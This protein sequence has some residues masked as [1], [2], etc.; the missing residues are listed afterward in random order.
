MS[1]RTGEDLAAPTAARRP[2]PSRNRK[3]VWALAA[4]TVF[5]VGD[6]META[7]LSP[8][9]D[10]LG[11]DAG[12]VALLWSAY[13]ASAAI[14]AWAAGALAQA[15]GSKRVIMTGAAIWLA[16][17]VVFLVFGV[18][19]GS[20][21]LMLIA[22]TVRAA[23]YAMFAF[24]F[25]VWVNDEAEPR[26]LHKSVGWY[27]FAYA[28][29]LGVISSYVAG[30]TLPVIGQLGTLWLAL[31]FVAAGSAIALFKVPGAAR[32][33]VP[34]AESLGSLV[35]GITVIRDHPRVGIGGVVRVINT[36]SFYAFVAFLTTY[37]VKQ[38]GFSDTEW[39]LIWGT[40]LFANVLANIIAGYGAHYLGPR[41]IIT[42]AGGFGCFV[43][44][45]ALY[46]VPTWIGPNFW[47]TIV[48]AVVYGLALG[49]FVPLSALIPQLAG[50]NKGPAIAVLNLGAGASQLVGPVLASLVPVIGM[51]PVVWV[52]A[53]LYLVGMVLTQFLKQPRTAAAIA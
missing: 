23:G 37:M 3:L 4:L 48:I 52:I 2:G 39:Q 10:T 30:F 14:A 19:V 47:V 28:L 49:M 40:M 16:M 46:F 42:W 8:Y 41:Q 38:I 12:R 21:P 25:L 44:V 11:F 32:R 22:F 43:T 31:A 20:Y 13:G 6:G 15:W 53:T 26:T 29:G 1:A 45:L 50:E 24:G 34:L 51:T 18:S 27:W 33:R 17:H 7:F 35:R 5:M 36:T 9:L